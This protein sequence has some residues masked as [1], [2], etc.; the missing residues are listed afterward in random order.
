MCKDGDDARIRAMQEFMD[1]FDA[2][3]VVKLRFLF[4]VMSELV[5]AKL[6][7]PIMQTTGS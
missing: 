5:Y 3:D 4:L 7:F 1:I 6:I 2:C